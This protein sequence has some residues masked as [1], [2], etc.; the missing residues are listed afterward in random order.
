MSAVDDAL[1]DPRM[2]EAAVMLQVY[3]QMPFVPGRAT[4]CDLITTDG[5]HIL[6]LWGGHAVA[7]LGHGHPSLVQA[8]RQQS[9]QIIFQSNAVAL[10][11]RATAAELL[12][13]I[14]PENLSRVFFVNSGA[15]ANENA[16][17]LS[18]MSTGRKK[19]LALTHGFHGRT[20]AS[21]AVTW[22]STDSWYGFPN[23][24][25]A[26][27]FIPRNDVAAARSMIDDTVAAVIFEPVQGV[28]GAFDLS[29]E[30]VAALREYTTRDGALLISDEV[31]CGMG[32]SGQY[33]AAQAY[34]MEPDLLTTAKG[35]GGGIPCGAL[36]CSENLSKSVGMGSLGSTFGGGPIAAAAIIA[37]IET[38]KTE[39]LRENVRLREAEIR[40]QCVTGPVQ[41]IQ[42]MGLL[43]GL[44]CDRPASEVRSALLERDILTGTSSDPNVLRLLPPLVLRPE[45]VI[46]LARSLGE[47]TPKHERT[48]EE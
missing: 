27:D 28:A 34:D 47:I 11:A 10:D 17:R 26:V 30:F 20:A 39:R 36:L 25:F 5:R 4:G 16:L 2:R 45:H 43:L 32:R 12:V 14:A 1:P 31:Q 9:E 33:F 8:I 7:V 37:V 40:A 22:N 13:G 23:T 46:R 15:E 19:V 38:I 18:C 29:S 24:P 48:G 21:G 3:G 41:S 42:G 35:L 6:D 44:V